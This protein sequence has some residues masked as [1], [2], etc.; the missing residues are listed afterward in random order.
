MLAG[1]E[2]L[3]LDEADQMLDLGFLPPIRRIVSSSR[4]AAEPVLLRDDAARNR[5]PG[6]RAAARSRTELRS[7]RGDRPSTA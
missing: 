5:P 2:I 6:R 3:V 4:K 1:T 7:P